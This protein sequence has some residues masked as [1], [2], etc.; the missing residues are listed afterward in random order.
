MDMLE[1][2][3][4]EILKGMPMV[5]RVATFCILLGEGATV[6]IFNICPNILWK[7]FLRRLLK[8]NLL[9]KILH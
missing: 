2:D 4:K 7:M 5:E 1:E 3:Y 6:K 8:L 9:I